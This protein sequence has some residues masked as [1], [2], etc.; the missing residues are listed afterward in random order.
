MTKRYSTIK[1][2]NQ[3]VSNKGGHK[4]PKPLRKPDGK[5]I[6][7]KELKELKKEEQNKEEKIKKEEQLKEV[8]PNIRKNC[9]RKSA[10]VQDEYSSILQGTNTSAMGDMLDPDLMMN[11]ISN[12]DDELE[13]RYKAP[14]KAAESEPPPKKVKVDAENPVEEDPDDL[15]ETLAQK[16]HR[17]KTERALASKLA[18]EQE[19]AKRL[20]E[21]RE[22]S[23]KQLLPIRVDG[24]TILQFREPEESPDQPDVTEE[25]QDEVPEETPTPEPF[26]ANKKPIR[27][28]E[29]ELR[30]RREKLLRERM[31]FIGDGCARILANPQDRMQTLKEVVSLMFEKDAAIELTVKSKCAKA[32]LKLFLSVVPNYRLGTLASRPGAKLKM[33]SKDVA[34]FEEKLLTRYEAYLKGLGGMLAGRRG[35]LSPID[36]KLGKVAL[37]C[38]CELLRRKPVFNCSDDILDLLLPYLSHK[39]EE[40]REIVR[41]AFIVMFEED[42]NMLFSKR[43]VTKLCKVIRTEAKAGDAPLH[44][45]AFAVFLHLKVSDTTSLDAQEEQRVTAARERAAVKS[46]LIKM[47]SF[48]NVKMNTDQ[49]KRKRKIALLEKKLE[50]KETA[51]EKVRTTSVQADILEM[52][53]ALYLRTLKSNCDRRTLPV[54]LRGLAKFGHLVNISLFGALLE[55]L[56]EVLA[57]RELG[58]LERVHCLATVFRLASA[59]GSAVV[60][61]PGR[62]VVML[63]RL[64]TS[65]RPCDRSI[66]ALVPALRVVLSV[67][68]GSK[69]K[70]SAAQASGFVKM[71]CSLAAQ[72]SVAHAVPVLLTVRSLLLTHGLSSRVL[73]STAEGCALPYAPHLDHPTLSNASAQPLWELAWLMRHPHAT[74]RQVAGH[75]ALGAPLLGHGALPLALTKL[76][77]EQVYDRFSAPEPVPEGELAPLKWSAKDRKRIALHPLLPVLE[78]PPLFS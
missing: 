1:K 69:H 38:L 63:Y 57:E 41:D 56:E 64:L 55:S 11:F 25:V 52:V 8:N 42:P 22:Q 15:P 53:F 43:V 32:L 4:K 70:V 34:T 68:V 36:V 12:K 37:K 44:E 3:K 73:D 23:R 18:Q 59:L 50:L 74:V 78:D 19:R 40:F 75:L 21:A 45:D 60:Q 17:L 72:V 7:K 48:H 33:E 71:L 16:S 46:N 14:K 61:D 66:E 20:E 5:K 39:R 62:Y 67:F 24:E 65:M 29:E 27:I 31:L 54:V 47:R 9:K 2:K 26:K 77:V 13:K 6:T 10:K 35:G 76:T 28:T 51:A 49:K 58:A 30:A